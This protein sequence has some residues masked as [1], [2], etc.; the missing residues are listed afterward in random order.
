MKQVLA[1]FLVCIMLFNSGCCSVF[2]PH[3]Q[4]V[5]VDSKPAGAKIKIGPY[6]GATPYQV[7]IPRGKE[8]VIEATY[9]DK[10]DSQL[11][12]RSIEP[13]YWV[14]ILFFPGLFIDLITGSMF[15]YEPTRYEF[16]FN[17]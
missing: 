17:Q 14:N 8:Y 15:K 1:A 12:N 4:K 7:T 2:T 13:L 9:N 16:D 5:M 10:S 11:L 6:K 3:P